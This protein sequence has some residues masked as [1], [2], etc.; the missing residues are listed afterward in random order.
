MK[1]KFIVT[2]T[3]GLLGVTSMIVWAITL[4]D[5]QQFSGHK[6]WPRMHTWS[7]N[8]VWSGQWMMDRWE[9]KWIEKFASTG[10][11]QAFKA[12]TQ[13]AIASGDYTAFTQVHIKY[14]IPTPITK[15]QFTQMIAKQA[16]QQKSLDALKNGD[17]ATWQSLNKGN[18]IL[19]KIDTE[20][21]FQQFQQLETYR[22]KM[23]ALSTQLGIGWPKGEGMGMWRWMWMK[24]RTKKWMK[25]IRTRSVNQ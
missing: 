13:Q 7:G 11:A 15:D 21:K 2:S 10:D 17:Y 8:L 14:S 12:A 25:K 9:K 18:P 23:N 24:K 1:T 22:E 3:I 6:F 20:A 16:I 19:T 4:A 5:N